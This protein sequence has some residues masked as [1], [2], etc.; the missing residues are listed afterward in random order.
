MNREDLTQAYEHAQNRI[1]DLSQRLADSEN[2]VARLRAINKKHA[3]ENDAQ[4]AKL[5]K[6]IKKGNEYQRT[7]DEL[8]AEN[9]RLREAIRVIPG[10]S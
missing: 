1:V 8:V 2:H 4:L 6:C 9:D 3:D 5:T 10:E 7:I